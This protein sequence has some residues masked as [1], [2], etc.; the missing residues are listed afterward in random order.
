VV[1]EFVRGRQDERLVN[2]L[3]ADLLFFMRIRVSSLIVPK[4]K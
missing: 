3:N 1:G 2:R 4:I